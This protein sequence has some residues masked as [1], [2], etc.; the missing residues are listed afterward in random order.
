MVVGE[1]IYEIDVLVLG[2]GPGGY[3]AA[4][5]AADLGK[6]VMLVE[7]CP[8]LGGVCLTQGCIPSKTLI[9]VVGIA[10]NIKEAGRMGLVHK[11][12]EF[13]P[14]TLGRY[15]HSVVKS[16]SSGVEQL[17]RSREIEVIQG[18]ARFIGR[19][20]VYVE[21]A[22]TIIRFNH[23]IIATGSRINELP[24]AME[25]SDSGD[26]AAGDSPGIGEV[27]GT[28]AMAIWTSA[29]ALA[30]TEIPESLLV[31]GGGYIGLEIGQ[32]YAGLGSRV[33]LVEFSQKLLSGAD[34]DLVDVV[35]KECK[36][37]FAAIHTDSRVK[38]IQQVPA[39]FRVEIE[40]RGKSMEQ[41]FSRV[42]A[43]T[44]RRPN[45]D[46]LGLGSL[47]LKMDDKGLILTD[48]QC[49]TSLP[50]IFA[51]GDVTQGPAL[52]HKAA[53]EGKVAAEV[54]AG[55]L[56]VFDNVA[57][58]AVFFTSPEI[59]WTG[60]TE[61]EASARGIPVK[62]GKFPL[63]ALGRARSAGKFKGFVKIIAQPDTQLVL[64]VGIVGEHASELI[65]EGTL[66]IE[67]GAC[68]EDLIVSIHPHPTFSEAI[69]EAAE[70]TAV[71]MA[72]GGSVHLPKKIQKA[73]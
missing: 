9:H 66:A 7:S 26:L 51:V 41:T 46:D 30:V 43:A 11:G 60:L 34:K 15:I 70:M 62:V 68:L 12:I 36:K 59:A 20:R 29:K 31:I 27:P 47:D 25:L 64:G 4:I 3:T 21:G 13:D 44:G 63:T 14:P 24:V 5:H 72:P 69:M 33:T 57:V 8:R 17:V 50:R 67:M 2:G 48:D 19:D 55:Q 39:G 56:S 49:R 32:A 58:P 42:L 53:R 22:N 16:L 35:V 73:K 71:E 52:A 38:R 61:D 18:H 65:A 10:N 54:I 1:L 23:A 45:T 28:E 6:E 37:Q 40:T